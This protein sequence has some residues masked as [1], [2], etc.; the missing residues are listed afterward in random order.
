M[1]TVLERIAAWEAAGLLDAAT[2][3]RL[4]AAEA[5]AT[6]SP[7]L[8]TRAGRPRTPM[9]AAAGSAFGPAPTIVEAFVYLGAG[10]FI[11]AWSAFIARIAGESNRDAILTAGSALAAI[12]LL[13]LGVALRNQDARR[14]RFGG[15]AL[16][17]ATVAAAIAADALGRVVGLGS[18][19]LAVTLDALAA[20]AVA[21]FGRRMLP[22]ATTQVAVLGAL[23]G[24]AA[25]A[26]TWLEPIENLPAECCIEYVPPIADPIRLVL[27]PAVGW[28]IVALGFGLL[29][30]AEARSTSVGAGLR[31]AVTRFWA[32]LLAVIGVATAVFRQGYLGQERYGRLVEPWLG[33]IIVLVLGA[34]LLERAL[35]RDSAAFVVAGAVALVTALTDF[36]F[37]YLSDST[38]VGLLIE[39]A[40][41]L[42]VGF[43][44]DR[45]RRRLG[46][47][48]AGPTPAAEPA[49]APPA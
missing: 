36:N 49:A 28:L 18:R 41:L 5:E 24:L 32:G 38:D 25:A 27:L 8:A 47:G 2:A 46:R 26:F 11:G 33:E 45:L 43:G 13:G 30:L 29:G 10:F 37:T 3:D 19:P 40:I 21:V 16:L 17:V 1:D 4:R 12:V 14:R 35:R 22:A 39:G 42:G 7:E 34:I 15:A 31:A 44:A 6:T 9:A 48:S 20:V 23:T